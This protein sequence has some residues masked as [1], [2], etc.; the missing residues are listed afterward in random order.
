MA[1]IR[2]P[3]DS[4]TYHRLKEYQDPK[5][6]TYYT[7]HQIQFLWMNRIDRSWALLPTH[8]TGAF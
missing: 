7:S 4:D 8:L 3:E 6:I 1:L 5:I 2:D